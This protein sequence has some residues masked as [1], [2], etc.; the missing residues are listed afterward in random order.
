MSF[1][2]QMK[3]K[4]IISSSEGR[5]VVLSVPN[6]VHTY[7]FNIRPN[8]SVEGMNSLGVWVPVSQD[9]SVAIKDKIDFF[10]W[11][12]SLMAVC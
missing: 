7:H 9:V 12:K 5:E 8:G 2:D 6:W 10:L 3:I 4:T 11:D 1:V